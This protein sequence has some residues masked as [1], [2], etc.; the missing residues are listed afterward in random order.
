MRV[1]FSNRGA[2]QYQALSK[3]RRVKFEKQIGFL[4]SNFRHPSL[5]AKKY[6]ETRDVWQARLN[7]NYRFYFQIKED[8][9]RIISITPHPK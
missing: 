3:K 5:R 2:N 7:G 8:T 1:A 9:Y 6:D 4:L